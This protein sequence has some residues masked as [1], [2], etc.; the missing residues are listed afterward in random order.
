MKYRLARRSIERL[1]RPKLQ[2]CAERDEEMAKAEAC[3]TSINRSCRR[4]MYR[5]NSDC[6]MST[7]GS[8]E[9]ETN[10]VWGSKPLM[11]PRYE[12]MRRQEERLHYEDVLR[13]GVRKRY[14]RRDINKRSR[15]R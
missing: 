6:N 3:E 2:R 9:G 15:K 12:E 11:N 5:E 7:A 1:R 14:E 8:T 4:L 10:V 13:S